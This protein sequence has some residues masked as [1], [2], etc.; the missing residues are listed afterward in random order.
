MASAICRGDDFALCHP[1][2][3]TKKKGAKSVGLRGGGMRH[4][5]PTR[6]LSPQ[7]VA[8][9]IND[10]LQLIAKAGEQ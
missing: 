8:P 3:A 7:N 2:S 4:P 5:S 6:R 1:K 10:Q 9:F